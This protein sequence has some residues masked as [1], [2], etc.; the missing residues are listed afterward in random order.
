MTDP[1]SEYDFQAALERLGG[2]RELLGKVLRSF[3]DQF[4]DSEH[5]IRFYVENGEISRALQSIHTIKGTAGN[6]GLRR[7]FEA[8]RD[9]EADLRSGTAEG[10]GPALEAFSDTHGLVI[11]AIGEFESDND[12]GD[13]FP[14][15][16]QKLDTLALARVI[17]SL[18]GRL[19]KSDSRARHALSDLGTLLKGNLRKE[20]GLLDRAIFELNPEKALIIL[21]EITEKLKI[22][23]KQN[24]DQTDGSQ[25]KNTDRG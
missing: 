21:S 4:K 20:F 8:A 5:Q 22:D 6:I 2:N 15:H 11:R 12:S 13:T 25:R 17:R 1:N 9:L 16:C 24:G 18:R 14:A 10:F 3:Y 19:E 23:L 7:L